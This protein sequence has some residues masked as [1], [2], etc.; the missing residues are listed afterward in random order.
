MEGKWL[1]GGGGRRVD[2][3]EGEMVR[4]R[5]RKKPPKELHR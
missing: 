3:D 1:E 4:G 5:R 2:V